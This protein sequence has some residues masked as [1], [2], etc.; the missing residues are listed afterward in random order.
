MKILSL[1]D[2]RLNRH[3]GY[4]PWLSI[5]EKTPKR[6]RVHFNSEIRTHSKGIIQIN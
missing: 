5:Q 6:L 1:K 2:L 3:H 4:L